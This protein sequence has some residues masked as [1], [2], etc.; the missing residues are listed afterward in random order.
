MKTFNQYLNEFEEIGFVEEVIHSLVI[1]SG[2]PGAFPHEII[3][4]ESGQIGE[5]FTLSSD[6]VTVL[7]F[8]K[9][10]LK[11]GTRATRTNQTLQIP[12]D[13]NFLGHVINPL[14]ITIDNSKPPNH[15]D[16]QKRFVHQNPSDLH[17]RALISQSC[18]TG[19]SLVDMM[20][21]LGRGQRELII[22]DR[23]TGKSNFLLKTVLTQAGQGV[24]CVYT[25]IGKKKQ[26]IKKAHEFFQKH[27]VSKN[28]VIVASNS[29]DSA[30]MIYITPYTAITIAEYFKDTGKHVLIVLDDLTMHAKYYREISLL[31]KRF[32]GRNSYPGDIFYVHAKLLERSGNFKTDKGDVSITCLSVAET[33]QGDLTGYIQT[34]VMSM[35]DGHIFFDSDLFA[36][37]R[38]PAINPFLSVTRVGKQTQTI[39][40][41]EINRELSSFLTLFDKMQN[42]IHFGAELSDNIKLTLSTGNK[43]LTFFDQSPFMVVPHNIQMV[44]FCVLWSNGWEG[45]TNDEMRSEMDFLIDVYKKNKQFK[46]TVDG[47]VSNAKS[48]NDL[49]N[50]A[51]LATP[52][53][54]GYTKK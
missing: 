5:V 6:S 7:L 24:I 50:K 8:S 36:K 29:Q 32:P 25:T 10:S 18:E 23:K 42:Y 1:V 46:D 21:P 33:M 40:R 49:I 41:R 13:E 44:L 37:G 39:V 51:K 43:I 53:I 15:K 22:G 31:S 35:T 34:N 26:D 47:L 12:V 4:F 48:F 45:K 30:G 2:L 54:L 11:I 17:T 27:G 16:S 38:R 14:G 19:V 52:E 28:V 3:V 20:I 9:E